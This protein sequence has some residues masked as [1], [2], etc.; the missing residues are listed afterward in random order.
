MIVKKSLIFSCEHEVL[1]RLRARAALISTL[2]L[3]LLLLDRY[4]CSAKGGATA[5][6][7]IL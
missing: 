5:L 3:F 6:L 4:S 1:A 2:L 7:K